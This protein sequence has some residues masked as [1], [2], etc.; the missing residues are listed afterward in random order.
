M[1]IDSSTDYTSLV[2]EPEI[3]ALAV[4]LELTEAFLKEECV[5]FIGSGIGARAGLPTWVEL[6]EG[7]VREAGKVGRMDRARQ[8]LQLA[9]LREGEVNAVAENVI[10]SIGRPEVVVEHYRNANFSNAALP[11]AYRLLRELPFSAIL[12][13]NYDNLL[14]RALEGTPYV[15]S[16]TPND[17]ERLMELVNLRRP[18]FLLKLYGDLARPE[19]VILGPTDYQN[20]VRSHAGFSRFIEGLFFSRT[21]LFLGTSLDGLT[22]YLSVF[23]FPSGV[24][25][26]HFAL[27]AV[28]GRGWEA[29]AEML[30]RRYN[31]SVIPYR[32]SED[33]AEVDTFLEELAQ[34]VGLRKAST[35]P[36]PVPVT[37]PRL[38]KVALENIGPFEE[39]EIEFPDNWKILLGDN[40]VGKSTIL[41]AIATAIVGSEARHSA[42]PLLRVGQTLGSVRLETP[43]NP[44]GYLAEIQRV[45]PAAEV[46]NHSA[47]PLEVEGWIALGFPALRATSWVPAVG[48]QGM[49]VRR[50]SAEDLLPLVRG[51]PDTRMD[52]LKQWLVNTDALARKEGASE[53]DRNRARAILAR[54]FDIVG[55]LTDAAIGEIT[56]ITPDYQVVVRTVDG[57]V[58]IESLSQGMTSLLSWVGILLQRLYEV[59]YDRPEVK[60]PTQEYALVL[61]DELDAH[62]HPRWQQTLIPK[63]KR[64]FPNIQVIASTHSPLVVGGLSVTEVVKFSRRGPNEPV[65]M[66]SVDPDMMIG[67]ADQVLTGDLFDLRT[68]L[69]LDAEGEAMM[70][71]YKKLL[72]TGKRTP[73]EE[74]RFYALHVELV[75]RI[76]P[77]PETKLERRAHELAMTVLEADYR[78]ENLP[79]LRTSFLEKVREIGK[80]MGWETP[81]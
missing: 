65:E 25:R 49:G 41:K 57:A 60:D 48:P 2:S 6:V 56:E 67:R 10:S 14:D 16:L 38:R 7:L 32:L 13:S 43:Q 76:P 12:T 37:G 74:E 46:V 36:E 23:T 75:D 44:S 42:A 33:F 63:L 8:E 72:A 21:L 20:L 66:T 26:P 53:A 27:V 11:K 62:M 34:Q 64:L 39:L 40:G 51:K 5:G 55:E 45:G 9:A 73:E 19:T 68:T 79:A 22:D 18:P 15:G 71:E 4:P 3:P 81:L 1:A 35:S 52:D 47:R 17:L 78:P 58:P 50:P 24:P 28:T 69:V 31:I 59:H 70:Q 77:T 80:S 29:K 54:F 30:R 61:M